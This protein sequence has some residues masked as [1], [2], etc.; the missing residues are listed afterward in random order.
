MRSRKSSSVS[1]VRATPT[2]ANFSG[3]SR[4]NAS[5]Y[6]AGKSFRCVRSPLAPKM[7]SMQGSGVR[8]SCSPSSSGFSCVVATL[9]RVVARLRALERANGVA[10]E[11]LPQRGGDLRRELDLVARREAREQRRRGY[12]T[13]SVHLHRRAVRQLL[14]TG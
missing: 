7:T 14:L 6:S 11:L 5:E 9:P 4:R 3:S 10:A 8:R 2:T 1:S 12:R 13:G